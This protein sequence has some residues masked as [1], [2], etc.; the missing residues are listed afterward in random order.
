MTVGEALQKRFSC[1]IFSDTPVRKQVLEEIFLDAFRTP[2]WANSQPWDIFVAGKEQV[3]ICLLRGYGHWKQSRIW[4]SF[5]KRFMLMKNAEILILPCRTVIC[6]MRPALSF[7]AWIKDFLHGL[8]MILEL[9][10]KA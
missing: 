5:L 8:I 3:L 2:S 4:I 1:R 10:P 9:F 7:S 6:F